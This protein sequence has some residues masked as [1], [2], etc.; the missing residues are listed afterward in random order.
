MVRSALRTML[1]QALAL[2]PKEICGASNTQVGQLI[3]ATGLYKRPIQETQAGC[4]TRCAPQRSGCNPLYC[5]PDSPWAEDAINSAVLMGKLRRQ[6]RRDQGLPPLSLCDEYL[7]FG[8]DYNVSLQQFERDARDIAH[9]IVPAGPMRSFD[10]QHPYSAFDIRQYNLSQELIALKK[11]EDASVARLGGTLTPAQALAASQTMATDP[12]TRKVTADIVAGVT[13]AQQG[14]SVGGA[15]TDIAA[16]LSPGSALNQQIADSRLI[17][18]DPGVK[19]RADLPSGINNVLSQEDELAR[20]ARLAA[21]RYQTTDESY[22]AGETQE[23]TQNIQANNYNY[24]REN[25]PTVDL[26]P[27]DNRLIDPRMLRTPYDSDKCFTFNYQGKVLYGHADSFKVSPLQIG[28]SRCPGTPVVSIRVTPRQRPIPKLGFFAANR[29]IGSIVSVIPFVGQALSLIISQAA[30][31]QLKSFAARW[32]VIPDDF[33]PQ[34]YP[35]AFYVIL[36]LDK[37]Q[38]AVVQPWYVPALN[39]QFQDDVNMK[40]INLL[41]FSI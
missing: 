1:D 2:V 32:R 29:W 3:A 13:L 16:R 15:L 22:R 14:G 21:T 12:L 40:A 28:A 19:A 18:I 36:P 39:Q 27:E 6:S 31:S 4:K 17:S 9:G 25:Y 41:G 5:P 11:Q 34:Y 23:I 24:W 7:A 20:Q 33:S 26:R 30:A 37:A 8:V 10:D 38:V 35:R